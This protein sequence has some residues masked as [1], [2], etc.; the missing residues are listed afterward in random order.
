MSKEDVLN[1]LLQAY[2]ELAK[3]YTFIK[4]SNE[5]WADSRLDDLEKEVWEAQMII[6]NIRNEIKKGDK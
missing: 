4:C 2:I 1:T 6:N 3:A 5:A